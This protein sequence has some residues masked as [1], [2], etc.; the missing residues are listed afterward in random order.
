[1]PPHPTV[2]TISAYVNGWVSRVFACCL[3]CV[4][5]EIRRTPFRSLLTAHHIAAPWIIHLTN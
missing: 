1:M 4:L 3:V 2:M 5:C